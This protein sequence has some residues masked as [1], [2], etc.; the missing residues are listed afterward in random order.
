[1]EILQSVSGYLNAYDYEDITIDNTAGGKGFTVAKIKPTTTQIQ[2]DLG[3]ARVIIATL[4]GAQARYEFVDPT[5]SQP[6]ATGP[7]HLA[8]PGDTFTFV[9]LTMMLNFRIIRET[10]VNATLRVTYFR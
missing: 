6:V 4:E 8:N 7:G 1:M 5:V 9:N 10:G 3:K 2:R